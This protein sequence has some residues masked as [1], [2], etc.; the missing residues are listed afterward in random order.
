MDSYEKEMTES[1]IEPGVSMSVMEEAPTMTV[2]TIVGV[3]I[4]VLVT[5]AAV[6]FLG[7][8]LDCRQQRRLEKKM[9]EVKKLKNQRRI[10]T[11]TENDEISIANH[12]EQAGTSIAPAEILA[13]VP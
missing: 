3:T 4:V 1:T 12:M 5:I 7:V 8:L 6:F 10:N 2:A 9:G 13:T 11:L